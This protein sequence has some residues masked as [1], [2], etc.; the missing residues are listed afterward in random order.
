MAEERIMD[1]EGANQALDRRMGEGVQQGNLA[2]TLSDF[3]SEEVPGEGR[4][5]GKGRLVVQVTTA[6]RA[7]P[8]Q[9]ARVVISN[10]DGEV[11]DVQTTDNSGR[12][13][14]V[15]LNAPSFV[16]SQTPGN[17]RPYSGYNVRVEALG[18]FT[19]SLMNVAVFDRIESIQPVVLEPVG[20]DQ[21]E[22][23]RETD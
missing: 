8:V 13:S 14:G 7:L 15:E 9:G 17:I 5:D 4:Q 22:G 2:G 18:Y 19:Q 16:Y 20:E 1:F 3:T 12:T 21:L 6:G 23:D 10:T 11:I